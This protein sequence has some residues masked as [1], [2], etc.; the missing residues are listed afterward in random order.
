MRQ[1]AEKI[2]YHAPAGHY[3]L[4]IQYFK[5][6]LN[7]STIYFF[8]YVFFLNKNFLILALHFNF[9]NRTFRPILSLNNI[10]RYVQMVLSLF[11]FFAISFSNYFTSFKSNLPFQG[12]TLTS[13][14]TPCGCEIIYL[15]HL[16]FWVF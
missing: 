6:L 2:K 16:F 9:E 13:S 7:E 3:R 1:K 8:W 10:F 15:I 12:R 5:I 4:C 11:Y 14:I